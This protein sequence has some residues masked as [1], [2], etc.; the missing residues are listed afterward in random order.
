MPLESY[1]LNLGGTVGPLQPQVDGVVQAQ[2][3]TGKMGELYVGAAHSPL[4]EAVSRGRCRMACN[5]SAITFGTALTGT[6][7][8]FTLGNP[9]G[10]GYVLSI[11]HC[12]VTMITSTTAGSL[13]YAAGAIHSAVGTPLTVQNAY[14]GGGG[15]GVGLASAAC[16]LPAAPVAVRT[17]ASG[18]TTNANASIHDHVNGGI[19]IYPGYAITIQG[20]TIVGTGLIDMLWEEVALPQ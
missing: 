18:F 1:Q 2:L 6:A 9:T 12:G 4:F 3:R 8:T 17:L 5:Q 10:S 20:I 11:L 19:V 14:F 15:P 16:T 7:V 13:V